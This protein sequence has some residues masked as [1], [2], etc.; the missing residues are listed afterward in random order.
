MGAL[1]TYRLH[2]SVATITMDDGKVNVLSLAMLTELGAAGFLDRVVPAGELAEAA[3]GAA[4]G[5]ARLDL[6][7][8]A[9][10]KLRARQ[11]ALT[12]LRGAIDAD[13]AGYRAH[14]AAQLAG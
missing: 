1:V 10:T 6:D 14:L 9:A 3:A 8:H 5:L 7:A 12:A 2:D 4:A 13:D 11:L